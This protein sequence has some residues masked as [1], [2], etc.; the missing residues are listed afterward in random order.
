MAADDFDPYTSDDW[1]KASDSQPPERKVADYSTVRGF[2]NGDRYRFEHLI[3]PPYNSSEWVGDYEY[4]WASIDIRSKKADGSVFDLDLIID[5]INEFNRG[6]RAAYVIDEP[7][8][9]THIPSAPRAVML[10]SQIGLVR[11]DQGSSDHQDFYVVGKFINLDTKYF[12]ILKYNSRRAAME[13]SDNQIFC[14][15]LPH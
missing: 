9:V 8:S 2:F 15:L 10:L 3:A 14:A 6:G 1:G 5:E 11:V 4:T 13:V 12:R 7:V